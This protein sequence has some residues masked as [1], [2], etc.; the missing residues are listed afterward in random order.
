M[1]TV[2]FVPGATERTRDHGSYGSN[3]QGMGKVAF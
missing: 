3:G 2:L 1:K